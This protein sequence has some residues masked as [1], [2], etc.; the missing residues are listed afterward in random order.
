[1]IIRAG[2][3]YWVLV[4]AVLAGAVFLR[5]A[6]PFF[7]QAL[8]LIA[9]DSYQRLA[10][11]K[12]DPNLPVR[13][14]D[15]DEDSLARIGQ[16]PWPR[17]TMAELA[18]KLVAQGAAVVAFDVL[19]SEADQ[20]SPEAAI[21]RLLPD[22]AKLLAPMI[23]GHQTHDEVFE[24]VIAAIPAV[25][26]VVLTNR[27]T[28]LMPE[29][30]GFAVAGDDPRPF[31]ADFPGATS[32]LPSL[33]AAAAGLGSINWVPDRDQV[34]R[35]VPLIYRQDEQFVPTL[36]TE[37]LR[38]AQGAS[39]YILKASNANG[40]TA[41]GQ[42]TGLNHIKVG[43]V[44]IRPTRTAASGCSSGRAI[45]PPTFPPGRCSPERT[46]RAR[47]PAASCSS[48]RARRDWSIFARHRSTHRSRASR[49]MPRRSSTSSPAGC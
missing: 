43:E 4:A 5:V 41:F 18:Q 42:S 6:D 31:I 28:P 24:K 2:R 29:K 8:R 17:T 27:P 12:F 21:K 22:E 3:L 40:E 36:T 15:I 46:T 44:E 7:V 14:V 47:S 26:A 19:F 32:N 10:P 25:L 33:D 1:M 45:R 9:F 11:Q 16:W 23:E 48:G 35:R 20:T 13:I 38:V 39:T 49:F 34:I 37:A 30:A